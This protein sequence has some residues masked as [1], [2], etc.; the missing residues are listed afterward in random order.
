MEAA[1]AS[2]RASTFNNDRDCDIHKEEH[3]TWG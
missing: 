2:G 3:A 1:G